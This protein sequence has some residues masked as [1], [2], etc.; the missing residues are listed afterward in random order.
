VGFTSGSTG[1][2]KGYR[3][4]HQS[5]L[6]GFVGDDAEFGVRPDDVVLAPGPMSHS[7]A[8]YALVRGLNAGATVVFCRRF[9]PSHVLQLVAREGVT[10]LYGVPTQFRMLLD[11]SESLPAVSCDTVRLIL[12]TGAKWPQEENG[13]LTRVFP[14]AEFCEFYGCSELGYLTLAKAS[15]KIPARS[16]GRAFPDVVLTIRNR[17]GDVLAPGQIGLVFAKSAQMFSGYACG[18]LGSLAIA[19]NAMSVGDVGLL[20]EGGFLYLEGRS[21]R[22]IICSGRNVHPEEIEDALMSH[23]MISGAAVFGAS[24]RERGERLVALL[25]LAGNQSLRR[26]DVIGHLRPKLPLYKIPM[27]YGVVATWP[28]TGLG[29]PDFAALRDSY[30]SGQFEELD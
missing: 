5:W 27:H 9:R 14:L 8:L 23:A 20:D 22:M 12:S 6:S 7:L 24:E 28:I 18:E 10:V 15:E 3:R 19:G 21:N 16:V 2:P 25:F 30:D 11:R 26:A 17:Q 29:K 1:M 4:N 13:R